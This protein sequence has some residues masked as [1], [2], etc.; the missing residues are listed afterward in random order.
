V[1]YHHD[2]NRKPIH[3][4]VGPIIWADTGS[5]QFTH[6]TPGSRSRCILSRQHRLC[7]STSKIPPQ[8][9][10]YRILPRR[11]QSPLSIPK[12]K[13]TK[14][15]YILREA[16]ISSMEDSSQGSSRGTRTRLPPRHPESSTSSNTRM[17]P[18]S[19][20]SSAAHLPARPHDLTARAPSGGASL[21]QER[22]RE[23]KVESARESRRRSVDMTERAIQS[24]PVRTSSGR[25]ER[26]PSS[27]GIL[28]GKGMGVKQIE[29]VS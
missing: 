5:I 25:D 1:I 10:F 16:S 12:T 20:N 24:S 28:A 19:S 18:A 27:S 22:L 23:R 21:L 15:K 9:H 3:Q 2:F 8:A 11:S 4:S 7:E 17:T 13:Q 6:S 14:R 29:E 26:R